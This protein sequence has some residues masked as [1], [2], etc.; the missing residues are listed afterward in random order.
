MIYGPTFLS[1]KWGF[2]T[3]KVVLRLLCRSLDMSIQT[4]MGVMESSLGKLSQ[5]G[6]KRK[7]DV[8]LQLI[9]KQ[10]YGSSKIKRSIP[11]VGIFEGFM[12]KLSHES[13]LPKGEFQLKEIEK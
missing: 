2:G 13:G 5:L 4:V 9:C 11:D 8:R 7:L 1:V 10:N 12:E 6:F 3:G